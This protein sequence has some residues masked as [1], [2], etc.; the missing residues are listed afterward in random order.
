MKEILFITGNKRKVWQAQD[1]LKRFDIQVNN[2]D[3]PVI[4]IQSSDPHEIAEAKAAAAFKIAKSPL[5]IN[6]HAWSFPGLNGFPGGY[7]KDINHWFE[8]EDFLAL[9]N[10][11]Q[12]R[13]A[14]LTETIIYVDANK[15]KS[16]SVQIKGHMIHE[17]R[18][19][20]HVACER[21]VV[22]D[23]REKTIAEHIDAGEH[24]RDM[25]KSAWVPFGEW[26]A[27]ADIQ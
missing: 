27:K 16:F 22:Y 7:M 17:P 15:T 9:M 8:P 6:D 19:V 1:I 26:Y 3:L 25:E 24:A 10:G 12:D 23:G 4:E 11:K 5:I 21:V 2:Q 18:G 14:I 20:G 13:T